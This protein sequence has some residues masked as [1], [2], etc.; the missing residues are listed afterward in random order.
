MIPKLRM[1]IDF[2]FQAVLLG[3][4]MVTFFVGSPLWVLFLSILSSW[5]LLSAGQLYWGH[6]YRERKRDLVLLTLGVVLLL[7]FGFPLLSIFMAILYT[8]ETF[9]DWWVVRN[10]PRRFWDLV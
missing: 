6:Q 8:A 1:H 2:V 3:L 5:Q 9:M 7:L 10:R 4:F